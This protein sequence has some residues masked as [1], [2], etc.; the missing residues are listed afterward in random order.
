MRVP[1]GRRKLA[2]GNQFGATIGAGDLILPGTETLK[3][4]L[5]K[6]KNRS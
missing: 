4:L 3:A 5:K 2:I 1:V 6:D